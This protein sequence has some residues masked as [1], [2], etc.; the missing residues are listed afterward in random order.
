MR[1]AV[2]QPTFLPWAGYFRLMDMADHFV[3]LDDVQLARQSWQTR[4]RVLFG[5]NVHT[6]VVPIVH[7]GL[8]QTISETALMDNCRWRR[9]LGQSLEQNYSRAP[10]ASDIAD[11]VSTIQTGE[12]KCLS[13]FNIALI[14]LCAEYLEI[15][16]RRQ[17]SSDMELCAKQR[18]ERLIEICRLCG[19]DTYVAPSGSA[20]YL[21]EDDFEA[22]S[23]IRLEMF[24]YC[25]LEYPQKGASSFVSHL[26]IVDLVANVG[27]GG[28][29]DYIRAS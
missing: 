18:S 17:R 3:Y 21:K 12:Q 15:G 5:Q 14:E 23:S 1:C 10:Y 8:D 20:E 6:I 24:H 27:W 7:A 29:R 25:P 16:A 4:N 28:A 26:S 22:Q 9:K 13:E 11:I 2:M 19:C